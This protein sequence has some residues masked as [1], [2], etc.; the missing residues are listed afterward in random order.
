MKS[1]D[2]AAVAVAMLTAAL[3][4]RAQFRTCPPDA[5]RAGDTCVD[6]YEASVWLV[7]AANRDGKDN[8]RLIEK[9]AKGEAALKDLQKG[10]AAQLGCTTEPYN[11]NGYP[12]R[13]PLNGNW[14][15]DPDS[16]LPPSPGVYAVSVPG[17]LPSTCITWFRAEQACALSGKRLL[18][19]QEWQRAAQGT[20]DAG[21]DNH[22]TDCAVQSQ[23]PSRT[24]ARTDCASAWGARDMVGNVW[25]WVAD[26]GEAASG[27]STWIADDVACFGG[28][29]GDHL[30]GA[31][32]RGGLWDDGVNAGVFAAWMNERGPLDSG[33]GIGFRCGR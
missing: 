2:V 15:P 28:S 29:G 8:R 27:C 21:S 12:A 20:P 4:A 14:T 1:R 24:G 25:E 19:N 23:G 13:F 11:L 33:P 30:P 32:M 17:V 26:W 3:P 10:N 16:P 7:P 31:I 22:L 9:I 5:V 18:N 6:K